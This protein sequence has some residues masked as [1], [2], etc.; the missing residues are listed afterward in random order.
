[1]KK[2]VFL[3]LFICLT[4]IALADVEVSLVYPQRVAPEEVFTV[5]ITVNPDVPISGMQTNFK[6]DSTIFQCPTG[7]KEGNLFNKNAGTFFNSGTLDESQGGIVNA[8]G[9]IVG[10]Y[11][12][13]KFGTF[14]SVDLMAKKNGS[15]SSSDNLWNIIVAAPQGI[16]VPLSLHDSLIV[17]SSPRPN[18]DCNDQTVDARDFFVPIKYWGKT[19]SDCPEWDERCNVLD[20]DNDINALDAMEVWSQM[21]TKYT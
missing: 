5:N 8:F 19:A 6:C 2:V 13:N 15:F 9:V 17:C 16:A 4:Q 21:G 3:L 18:I 7:A 12:V 11:N 20:I 14:M 10:P 1:M